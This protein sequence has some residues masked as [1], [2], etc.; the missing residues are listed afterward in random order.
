MIDSEKHYCFTT[1]QSKQLAKLIELGTHNRQLVKKLKLQVT[2]FSVLIQQKDQS[3]AL[4]ATQLQN[5]VTQIA[6][7]KRSEQLLQLDNK[8]KTKKIKQQKFHKVL[9]GIG[10]VV[11]GTLSIQ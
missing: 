10:L 1:A 11:L 2:K 4:Q 7:Q 8:R 3:I 6:N 5:Q 9:L